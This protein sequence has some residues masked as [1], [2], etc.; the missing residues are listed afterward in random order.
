MK[1]I[2]TMDDG[3]T[4]EVSLTDSFEKFAQSVC[5]EGIFSED[6]KTFYPSRRISE[7]KDVTPEEFRALSSDWQ[8]AMDR[9][10]HSEHNT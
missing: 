1:A 5:S 10:R 9:A 8:E 7:V 6:R 3:K 4:V 2:V